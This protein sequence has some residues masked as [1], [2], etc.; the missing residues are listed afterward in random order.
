[1]IPALERTL[2]HILHHY[3]VLGDPEQCLLACQDLLSDIDPLNFKNFSILF[4]A[5]FLR[6]QGLTVLHGSNISKDQQAEK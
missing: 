2:L 5:N 3:V 4:A 1:M 6:L